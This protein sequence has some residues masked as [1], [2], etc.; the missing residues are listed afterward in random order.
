MSD[1]KSERI[2]STR[3]LRSRAR[4]LLFSKENYMIAVISLIV[5]GATV[6]LPYMLLA[7]VADFVHINAA[8]A[9]FIILELLTAAPMMLGAVKVACSMTSGGEVS[10]SDTFFAFSSLAAYAKSLIIVLLQIVKLLLELAGAFAFLSL[11]GLIPLTRDVRTVLS[12]VAAFAG[13]WVVRAVLSR[14]YGFLYFVLTDDEMNIAR[15]M[16]RSVRI[17]KGRLSRT[18]GFRISSLPTVLISAIPLGL[19]LLLYTIPYKLCGYSYY[20]YELVGLESDVTAF[21]IASVET[22]TVQDEN[23]EENIEEKNENGDINNE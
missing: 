17:C 7:L 9:F 15:A 5:C 19:P 11:A 13:F 22:N 3:V 4:E 14:F 2:K 6:A 21:E 23:N 8:Y 16:L 1:R 18:V 20:M 12:I 10:L